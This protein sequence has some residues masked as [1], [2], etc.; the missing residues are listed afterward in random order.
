MPGRYGESQHFD[1]AQY[2]IDFSM[3]HRH[4]A[5]IEALGSVNWRATAP[6]ALRL[7][8]PELPFSRGSFRTRL[9][10]CFCARRRIYCEFENHNDF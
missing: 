1:I 4:M 8:F 2:S 10:V 5:A 3:L 6:A 7:F 9:G